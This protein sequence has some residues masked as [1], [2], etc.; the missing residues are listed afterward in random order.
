ML[1]I[2]RDKREQDERNRDEQSDVQQPEEDFGQPQMEWG[3]GIAR[4]IHDFF[5]SELGTPIASVIA[6]ANRSAQFWT[7]G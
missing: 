6:R 7:E 4:M 2:R 5:Q 1:E 3:S